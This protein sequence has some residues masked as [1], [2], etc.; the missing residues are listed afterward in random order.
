MRVR[1]LM[2][3]ELV[4][5]SS[6]A[7]MKT[8][9]ERMLRERVGS[10]IVMHAG[11]PV[12]IITETD[13]LKL[14]YG[15]DRPFEDISVRSVMSRPLKTVEPSTTVTTLVSRMRKQDLK[16]FPVVDDLDLIGIVTMT[17]IVHNHTELLNEARALASGRG[18][19]DP[20]KWRGAFKD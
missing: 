5:V 4:T 19:R 12:G 1:E 14:G 16:K 2:S 11:S 8:A 9:A 20:K 18:K 3:T 15:A 6:T 13:A 17:D 7:S 10:V